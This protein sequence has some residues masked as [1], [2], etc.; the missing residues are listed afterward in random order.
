MSRPTSFHLAC[1]AVAALASIAWSPAR[2]DR[3]MNDGWVGCSTTDSCFPF[4]LDTYVTGASQSLLPEG[5]YPYDATI[6]PRGTEVWFVGA[7]GDGAVVVD[8]ATNTITHCI[9]TG[10]YP[11]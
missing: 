2:A 3:G 8:R 4:D 6:N 9:A 1:A 11:T 5:D 7:S 10:E